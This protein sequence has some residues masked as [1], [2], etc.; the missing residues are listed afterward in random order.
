MA[1][2][3]LARYFKRQYLLQLLRSHVFDSY[4]RASDRKEP[5][6]LGRPVEFLGLCVL[7]KVYFLFWQVLLFM[8][9]RH[10]RRK[11]GVLQNKVHVHV[12]FSVE[13]VDYSLGNLRLLHDVLGTLL[14]LHLHRN[15]GRAHKAFLR[16][17]VLGKYI[18]HVVIVIEYFKIKVQ[19]YGVKINNCS[20]IS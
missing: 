15:R 10:L 16:C 13:H 12:I 2:D 11:L 7:L 19:F 20:L 9:P 18:L 17:V 4:R 1:P 6:Q 3:R 8:L 14:R 5:R